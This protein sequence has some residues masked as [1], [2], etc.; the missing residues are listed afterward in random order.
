MKNVIFWQGEKSLSIKGFSDFRKGDPISALVEPFAVLVD[1]MGTLGAL[2]PTHAEASQ[3]REKRS[4]EVPVDRDRHLL[5][6]LIPLADFDV[7]HEYFEHVSAQM[8]IGHIL[9][10]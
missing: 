7:I 5:G 9:F 10:E 3:L 8:I 1:Y 4:S 2:R 6:G